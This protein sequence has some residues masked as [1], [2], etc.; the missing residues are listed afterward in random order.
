LFQL[1]PVDHVAGSGEHNLA[2]PKVR[3]RTAGLCIKFCSKR[4][5]RW[6]S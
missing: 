1:E 2:S 4:K 6:Y 3:Y 5:Y